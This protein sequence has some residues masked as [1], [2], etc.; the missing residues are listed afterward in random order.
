MKKYLI[1]LFF[2]LLTGC[3]DFL[4][5]PDKIDPSEVDE[6]QGRVIDPALDSLIFLGLEKLGLKDLGLIVLDSADYEELPDTSIDVDTLDD[7]SATDEEVENF[8]RVLLTKW[9]P[10]PWSQGV[11]GSCVGWAT[12]SVK[13]YHYN[14][15]MGFADEADKMRFSPSF[16]YNSI[17]LSDC[18]NGSYMIDAAEFIKETGILPLSEFPYDPDDEEACLESPSSSDISAAAE[19]RID[20]FRKVDKENLSELKQWIRDGHPIFAAISVD[21]EFMYISD[22]TVYDDAESSPY[23]HAVV[24][25]GFDNDKEAFLLYN[26]WGT[27]WGYNGTA[28]IKF[29]AYRDI[30]YET[31]VFFDS[32]GD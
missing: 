26:S 11:Q 12:A 17:R 30:I 27:D 28:W 21:D 31:Y 8:N 1:F 4:E 15:A 19:Y 2:T 25:A 9:F 7:D 14:R 10:E 20:D 22:S 29:S 3:L 6:A 32:S 13:N 5:P 18:A 23:G 16:V 24:F